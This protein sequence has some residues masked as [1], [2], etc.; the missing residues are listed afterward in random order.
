MLLP[1]KFEQEMDHGLEME[2]VL[3][4]MAARVCARPVSPVTMRRELC[5]VSFETLIK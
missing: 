4:A 5:S 2:N 3:T 1:S